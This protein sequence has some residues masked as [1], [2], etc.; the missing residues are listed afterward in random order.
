MKI[1][2]V[3]KENKNLKQYFLRFGDPK[4]V[5]SGVSMIHNPEVEYGIEQSY[6]PDGPQLQ[7]YESGIS[8]Y[9]VLNLSSDKVVFDVPLGYKTF[10]TQINNFLFDR[11]LSGD[12]YT[13]K[14][15]K[16]L[17]KDG[18]PALGTDGEPL[19][20]KETISDVK[21]INHSEIYMNENGEHRI[22]D[23]VEP[24]D[25]WHHF[26]AG[27][28]EFFKRKITKQ[29][30]NEYFNKLFVLFKKPELIALLKKAKNQF[31]EQMAEDGIV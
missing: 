8:A 12:I 17:K 27:Y 22:F 31:E 7:A 15:Q 16:V 21:R 9:P 25:L 10:K 23:M 11:L 30:L 14:A 18:T 13:F 3:L 29:E 28:D 1:K 20:K 19:L 6:D 26:D 5:S 2:V 24:W 4:K